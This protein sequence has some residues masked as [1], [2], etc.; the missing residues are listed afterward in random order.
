MAKYIFMFFGFV[1]LVIVAIATV[2]F[3]IGRVIA[4]NNLHILIVGIASI[5]TAAV[6]VKQRKREPANSEKLFFALV[7]TF[8]LSIISIMTNSFVL[9]KSGE[10]DIVSYIF[11]AK[12]LPYELLQTFLEFAAIYVTFHFFAKNVAKKQHNSD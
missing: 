10:T 12:F 3:V 6:F 9:I 1:L 5:L 11:S 2:F 4:I 8:I 7:V